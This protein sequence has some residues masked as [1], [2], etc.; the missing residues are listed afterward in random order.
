MLTA[1]HFECNSYDCFQQ[2]ALCIRLSAFR[3]P[4]KNMNRL[5]FVIAALLV[6]VPV[7]AKTPQK[8][9]L[10]PEIQRATQ[11]KFGCEVSI[12]VKNVSPAAVVL[13]RTGAAP[14]KLQS[15]DIQQWDEKL[16]WQSVGLGGM[17]LGM[18]A[19]TIAPQQQLED[20]FPSAMSNTDGS[21]RFVRERL[22]GSAARFE[23]SSTA[24]TNQRTNTKN[25]CAA[26]IAAH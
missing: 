21:V 4:I 14:P 25:L 8:A 7:L 16:G 26:T 18:T 6:V 11:T 2:L 9:N 5:R 22:S 24:C 23:R 13:G 15:L 10:A 19:V 17:F 3:C 1:S 20:S 12:R